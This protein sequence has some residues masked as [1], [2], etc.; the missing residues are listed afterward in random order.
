[1][2]KKIYFSCFITCILSSTVACEEH[3]ITN[4]TDVTYQSGKT[5]GAH[6][7]AN[8]VY[9]QIIKNRRLSRDCETDGKT[10]S[11]EECNPRSLYIPFSRVS[12]SER[13]VIQGVASDVLR[14][15]LLKANIQDAKLINQYFDRHGTITNRPLSF[16]NGSKFI[17]V[18]YN[19]DDYV[20][21][22]EFFSSAINPHEKD[23]RNI[24]LAL[25]KSTDV[26]ESK[27]NNILNDLYQQLDNSVINK[28]YKYIDT[29]STA[30]VTSNDIDY[31]LTFD[32]LTSD[33][34]MSIY[35]HRKYD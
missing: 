31:F 32:V 23:M 1:M 8:D 26:D 29:I 33:F 7:S 13:R 5:K 34:N 18:K 24:M 10:P 21:A 3:K 15:N 2:I 22:I 19:G 30:E 27:A 11:V 17:L 25:I 9:D 28:N 12:N 4:K 20:R 14:E 6:E 35:K 16:N